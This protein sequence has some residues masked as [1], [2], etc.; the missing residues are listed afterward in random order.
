MRQALIV[1]DLSERKILE[2][3]LLRAKFAATEAK[4]IKNEFIATMS[5]E[6]R[7]PLNIS[8]GYADLLLDNR[9]YSQ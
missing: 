1:S 8:T 2:E 6:L 5:H 3:E 7:P 9:L 4:R